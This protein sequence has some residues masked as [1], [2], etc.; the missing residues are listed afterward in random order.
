MFGLGLLK[1]AESLPAN[2][3]FAWLLMYHRTILS[4]TFLGSLFFA[5]YQLRTSSSSYKI[6]IGHS[7]NTGPGTPSCATSKA[8]SKVGTISF[9]R[10]ITAD[11]FTF[12]FIRLI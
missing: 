1:D 12:G 9:T 11:H 5:P 4:R 7:T 10:L 3:L 6:S 8:L 2:S